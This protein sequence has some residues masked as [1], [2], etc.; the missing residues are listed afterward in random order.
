MAEKNVTDLPSAIANSKEII[1]RLIHQ[2]PVFFMDY[3]GT[4]TPIVS[5]PEDAI[6]SEQMRQTLRKLASHYKVAIVSGRDRQDVQN[7]VSIDNLIYAGSH[8]FDI[9]GPDNLYLQHQKGKAALPELDDAERKLQQLLSSIKGSQVERKKY[10]IAVHFRN[11]GQKDLAFIEQVVDKVLQHHHK[12]RKSFGKK[13]YELQPD[14]E[15]DKGKAVLWLLKRLKLYEDHY[16]PVYVGDDLTDENAFRALEDI[17]IGILVGQHGKPTCADY[18][19]KDVA[20][21]EKFL[22]MVIKESER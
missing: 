22:E 14:I 13:I 1:G 16:L 8:G 4:L 7:L 21:V 10:S 15:W 20:E 19:L 2:Q 11:V 18:H 6:L 12:L 9:V 3:D 5:K 17:G